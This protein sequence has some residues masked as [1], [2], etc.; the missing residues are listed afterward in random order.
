MELGSSYKNIVTCRGGCVT[1]KKGFGLDNSIYWHL[2]HTTRDYRQ[3]QRYHLSTHFTVHRC[4]RT[5]VLSLPLVVSWQRIY[6]SLSLQITYEIF[7]LI[8]FLLLFCSCQ[9]RRLG[10]IQFLCS[11]VHIPA[12]WRLELDLTLFYT[13]E[14]FLITTSQGP[15][16]KHSPYCWGGVLTDPFPSNRYPIVTCVHSRGNVFTESLPSSGSMRHNIM[17]RP[18]FPT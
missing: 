2:R 6:N 10:S 18:L 14:H 15:R 16:R 5:R 1:Y 17:L 11:Q 12:G 13:V 8:P 4:A 9:F 7:R 3:I